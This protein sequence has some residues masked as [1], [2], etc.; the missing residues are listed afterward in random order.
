MA[1]SALR[2][3][4]RLLSRFAIMPALYARKAEEDLGST[5]GA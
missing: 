2:R 5:N 3:M 4:T 1:E